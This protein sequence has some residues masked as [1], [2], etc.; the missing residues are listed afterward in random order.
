[1]D[2]PVLHQL[3]K[4]KCN[5]NQK[6]KIQMKLQ[7]WTENIKIFQKKGLI[8]NLNMFFLATEKKSKHYFNLI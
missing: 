6:Y 3:K 8:C 5:Y 2:L 1:M 7:S 4:I